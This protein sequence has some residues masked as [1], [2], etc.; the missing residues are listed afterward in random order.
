MTSQNTTIYTPFAD[1]RPVRDIVEH[2]PALVDETWCRNLLR[3]TLDSLEQQYAN[4][5]PHRA[6]TPETVVMLANGEALLLPA[7]DDAPAYTADLPG[8]LHALALTVH[9]AITAELPP[10]GPLGPRLYDNYSEQLTKGLDSCLGPNRRLRPQTVDDMRRLLGIEA[11]TGELL[12][13]AAPV[14]DPVETISTAEPAIMMSSDVPDELIPLTLAD[15][16]QAFAEPAA[17]AADTASVAFVEPPAALDLPPDNPV[18]EPLSLREQTEAGMLRK[19]ASQ[20][21]AAAGEILAP[22]AVPPAA[23]L[24][25]SAEPI[26]P[27]PR[28]PSAAIP[29]SAPAQLHG[30]AAQPQA[31]KGRG[32]RAQRWGMITGAAIVVLAAG[33]ALL[34]YMHQDDTRDLVPLAL[35]AGE[36]GAGLDA[37]ET[38][39]APPSQATDQ[40]A[41]AQ[42]AESPLDATTGAAPET[43]LPANVS[44]PAAT[45]PIA[46]QAA[47]IVNGTTYKLVIKPWGTLYVDGVDHGVSPPVKRMTLGPGRHTIRITNPNFAD[48]SMTVDAGS[49][50]TAVIEHDFT[51]QAQ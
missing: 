20:E 4:G 17:P 31:N 46:T 51:A 47:T 13:P 12:V 16:P 15:D 39:V 27:A 6:I 3:H 19:P 29:V 33:G 50:E 24:H 38:V 36:P 49:R 10:E 5:A 40:P 11:G 25:E 42:P 43:G 21:G 18:P 28:K 32:K 23:P 34:S 9:Y 1:G 41:G 48:H 2:T 8:D 22:R 44:S 37:G 45:A 35:P 14:P 26:Q 30:S 7:S